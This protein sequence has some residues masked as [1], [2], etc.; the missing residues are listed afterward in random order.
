MHELQKRFTT[1]SDCISCPRS[2]RREETVISRLHIVHSYPL[3]L[4]FFFFEGKES[5]EY[6]WLELPQVSFLSRQTG[7]CRDKHVFV[8]TKL[9]LSPQYL[10]RQIFLGY[11]S[12]FLAKKDVYACQEKYC[13]EKN[14]LSRQKM[15]LVAFLANGTCV[16]SMYP[17][18]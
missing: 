11:F 6:H 12:Y 13:H 7:V 18:A 4:F 2:D 17:T 1:L 16:H 8:T 5:F 15:I 9:C 3:T 10:S 14:I